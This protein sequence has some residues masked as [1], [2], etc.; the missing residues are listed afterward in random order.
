MTGRYNSD[1]PAHFTLV[2]ISDEHGYYILGGNG[3]VNTCLHFDL[4]TIKF[5]AQMPQEKTFFS[6][7]HCNGIIYTFGGY[8]AYDKVQLATCEY[9]NI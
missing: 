8:D 7:L 6:A 9:Y 5:K 4:K 1:F 2:F 3:N